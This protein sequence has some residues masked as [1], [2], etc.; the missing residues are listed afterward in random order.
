MLLLEEE[1]EGDSKESLVH[2]KASKA[3]LDAYKRITKW[4]PFLE[5]VYKRSLLGLLY[6]QIKPNVTFVSFLQ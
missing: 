6:G 4:Q 3:N 2:N 5:Q 1:N